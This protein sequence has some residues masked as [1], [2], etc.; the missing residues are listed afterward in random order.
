MNASGSYI[1]M[2]CH[3]QP[4]LEDVCKFLRS[5]KYESFDTE[6]RQNI[7]GKQYSNQPYLLPQPSHCL[8]QHHQLQEACV[9]AVTVALALID[10]TLGMLNC[11]HYRS[12]VQ[13]CL[14]LGCHLTAKEAIEIVLLRLETKTRERTY[15][16]YNALLDKL[17][18][19]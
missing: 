1:Q 12:Q 11:Q 13:C 7:H 8:A 9:P 3:H 14:S 18:N 19:C 16:P 4:M 2:P 17:H 15:I 6:G 10:S 5:V